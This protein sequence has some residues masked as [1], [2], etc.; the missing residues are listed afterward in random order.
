M[1]I[2]YKWSTTEQEAFGFYYVVTKWNYYLQGAEVI[3]HNDQNP[4]AIFLNGKK[5]NSKVNR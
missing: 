5:T 4:L 3:V 1:D 2:Q